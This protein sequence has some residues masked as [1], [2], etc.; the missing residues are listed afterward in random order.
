MKSPPIWRV[1]LPVLLLSLTACESE[2]QPSRSPYDNDSSRTI[3]ASNY[4]GKKI[5]LVIGN[6]LYKFKP[7]NNPKN[8]ARQMAQL[9]SSPQLGFEVTHK[10][11][12]GLDEMEDEVL[13]FKLKLVK[14][15]VGLFYFAGH[16]LVVEGQNYLLPTDL[17]LPETQLIKRKS[18]EAQWVV[19]VM[20]NA[21]SQVSIV[22]LDACR[23]FPR[24]DKTRATNEDYGLAAMNAPRG[25]LIGFATGHGQSTPD[26]KKGTN[27]LYTGHLLK[28][29]R[30][31]GL[32]IEDVFKK[33]RQ[34]IA[35]ETRNK[36]VPPVYDSLI[37]EFC[38]VSCPEN[39]QDKLDKERR[40]KEVWQRKLAQQ[41]EQ[42]QREK[43]EAFQRRLAQLEQK[44][45]EKEEAFQRQ[46]DALKNQPVPVV[47]QR[48]PEKTEILSL[49]RQCE[50]YFRADY[51]TTSPTGTTTTASV[52]Y[53]NV[54]QKDEGN[55]EALAGLE[56]ITTRYAKLTE[57]ALDQ[58]KWENA[59]KYLARLRQVNPESPKLVA[60]TARLE[61]I[62][63]ATG[64]VFR[65][66]LKDGSKGPQMVWIPK[67][68]F[69]MGDIQGGGDDDEK[70]VHQ[71]S[72]SRFAMGRYEVTNA[73][74]VRFLNTVNHRGSKNEPWFETKAEDS[75]SHITG[76]TGNFRVEN[77]YKNHP[78][79]EVSWY[80]A[81]AYTKW[82][83]QQTGQQYRLP[84]EAEWEYAARAG[85]KTKYWWGN[86][87]GSN[88]ANCDKNHCGDNFKYTS[89]VGSFDPS[90][91]KL[92]DMLGNVWEWTCSEYENK[93]KGKEKR[94]LSKNRANNDSRLS[95]RGGAWSLDA[96]RMRSADRLR[97]EPAYRVD[98]LGFRVAR[99]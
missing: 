16:G 79:I 38:L 83:S 1:L 89:P 58:K 47:P 87:I 41:F 9:L 7:L 95:F 63:G 36:Q 42:K 5:A 23:T 25:T 29:M 97:F 61:N 74:F 53:Q 6:W 40:E 52:C 75:D 26:G 82:L 92:Y 13:K 49:L 14:G 94:C 67:G 51:L 2:S 11:N 88:K 34:Q 62:N 60:L 3:N 50:A 57:Q 81:I 27:G 99:L 45:R 65:D 43:E 35:L 71:V 19:E 10:E 70:P 78:V 84:T 28:F 17:R 32:T 93:Y 72:V 8:D 80:G 15:Q 55:T 73:E 86:D 54:L 77:G 69:R 91:F 37:G 76:S 33:T 46:L 56:K 48:Q 21:G 30:Q 22:I 90:P 12:L 96:R 4:T 66:T 20:E 31:P 44:Q 39:L 59:K 64:E 98:S 85:T 68:S 24:P 18:I